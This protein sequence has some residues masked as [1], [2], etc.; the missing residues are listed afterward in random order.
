MTDA[1]PPLDRP[2][3]L[4]VDDA[5]ELG[6]L[7]GVFLSQFGYEVRSV[8]DGETATS[9]AVRLR[10][11]LICLDLMLPRMCGIAVCELLR[12]HPATSGAVIVITSARRALA[13]RADAMRAGADAF[14]SKPVDFTLLA[15]FASAALRQVPHDA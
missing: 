15:Q 11:R 3:A 8:A 7:L 12:S 2:L 13:D 5:P 6:M 1:N 14:L 9:E 10:P 4:V